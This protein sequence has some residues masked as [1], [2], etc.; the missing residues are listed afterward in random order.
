MVMRG[1]LPPEHALRQPC[2]TCLAPH[3][4]VTAV[5][6]PV[7]IID[8][9]LG[10]DACVRLHA[11]AVENQARFA[12]SKV[13][14]DGQRHVVKQELR[15]SLS[16]SGTFGAEM[17]PFHVALEA[18][19]DRI[20]AEVGTNAF[21][22]TPTELHMVAHLHGQYLGRHIDTAIST[23][24][25]ML[26]HERLVTVIYYFHARP[27]AFSGGELVVYPMMGEGRQIIE[28]RPDRLVAIPS[29]APHEI[30]AVDVPDKRFADSRFALVS[31]LA[32]KRARVA[33]A[34]A[35]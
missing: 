33:S 11:F 7:C 27:G 6:F 10:A 4:H 14:S 5:R 1:S 32:R 21:D 31:W 13:H 15:D 26:A 30:I 28:P 20:A 2:L 35:G 25:G 19:Y 24:E 3:R 8:D 16:Y 18:S 29:F 12:P 9:F 34:S 23:T 17:T 22:R